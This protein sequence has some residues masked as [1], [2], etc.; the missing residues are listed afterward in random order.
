MKRCQPGMEEAVVQSE[1]GPGLAHHSHGFLGLRLRDG[2]TTH[3][4]LTQHELTSQD[5][6]RQR[7]IRRLLRDSCPEGVEVGR[8]NVSV[9]VDVEE[10]THVEKVAGERLTGRHSRPVGTRR[11]E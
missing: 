8:A 7:V 2:E 6:R 1:Y 4:D 10:G 5:G 11:V 9:L 3:S